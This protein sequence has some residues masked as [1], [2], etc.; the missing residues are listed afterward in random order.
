MWSSCFKESKELPASGP[1]QLH[2]ATVC[3]D[4]HSFLA[5]RHLDR[6][7]TAVKNSRVTP[8]VAVLCMS[9]NK[10]LP[11][12]IMDHL[13]SSLVVQDAGEASW[14]KHCF[15]DEA[16]KLD[17]KQSN[18]AK[19]S[20]SEFSG[21][22]GKSVYRTNSGSVQWS[23]HPMRTPEV[24]EKICEVKLGILKHHLKQKIMHEFHRWEQDI[25][26]LNRG[27]CKHKQL[28]HGW[29]AGTVLQPRKLKCSTEWAGE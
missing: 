13:F 11:K 27:I 12:W 22:N 9:L 2:K 21:P 18:V 8:N 16:L 28:Q 29:L 24:A 3:A 7:T 17:L 6:N 26:L 20:N 4:L 14:M 15:T 25:W 19:C 10:I 5:A 23:V 1:I